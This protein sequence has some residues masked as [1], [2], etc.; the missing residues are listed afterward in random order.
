MNLA[1]PRTGLDMMEPVARDVPTANFFSRTGYYRNTIVRERTSA[2]LLAA[3]D[4]RMEANLK[5]QGS[6]DFI[7]IFD[8]AARERRAAAR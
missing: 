4:E 7:G 2:E 8:E 3:L 5:K 1:G 6:L